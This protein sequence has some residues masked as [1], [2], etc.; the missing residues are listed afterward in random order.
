MFSQT[1][2]VN[3]SN[4]F[5]QQLAADEMALMKYS[6][7]LKS[8]MTEQEAFDATM[9]NASVAAQQYAQTMYITGESVTEFTTKQKMAEIASMSQNKSFANVR[10]IIN[11]YNGGL[12]QLGVT[13]Q[14]FT[15]SVSQGNSVLGN[16]IASVGVGNATMRGYIGSLIA[17]KAATIGLKVATIALNAVIGLGIGLLIS[18]VTSALSAG[19][20]KLKDAFKSTEERI[21]DLNEKLKESAS[22]IKT[23]SDSFR[24]LKANS[25]SIFPRFVE[26]AKGVD[27]FGHN[28][29]LTDEEYKEFLELNNKIAEM[30]PELNM[31]MDSNG[32]AMLSLS[33]SADTLTDSL[34]ALVEAERQAANAEI[35]KKMP[36]TLESISE[37]EKE[38]DKEIKKINE[39]KE[40]WTDTYNDI[41]NRTLDTSVGRYSTIDAGGAAAMKQ[42]EKAAALGMHGNVVYDNQQTTNNGYVF[43]IQWDYE[44]VNM[45]DVKKLY[46]AKIE[47]ESKLINNYEN[48]IAAKWKEINPIIS[49]WL[50]TDFLYNDLNDQ[51]QEIANVMV[52][53]L[54]FSEL[55]LTTQEDVQNYVTNNIVRPLFLASDDVKD[56]FAEI[57]DLQS[58]LKN[59][60]ITTEEF[61]S[62]VQNAFSNLLGSMDSTAVENFKNAFVSGFNQA[63]I[64]GSNFDDVLK[65]LIDTWGNVNSIPKASATFEDLMLS[66][67][68]KTKIDD[69][70]SSVEELQDALTK[71]NNGELEPKDLV[72]LFEKFPELAKNSDNLSEAIK[73]QI[74][75]LTGYEATLYQNGEAIDMSTGIMKVFGEA[76][77]SIESDEAKAALEAFM[78]EV[79]KLGEVVGNTEFTIDIEAEISGMESLWAAMKES[80]SSTGL[81]TESI[82][83]LKARYQDLE[84]Y[85]AARLFEKTANGIHLNTKALRELESEYEK[86]TKTDIDDALDSLIEQYNDLTEQINNASDTTSTAELYAKRNDILDQINDTAELASMYDGLTSAFKRW[87]QAQSIGEEGDMYDSLAGGLEHIKELYDEGLIGTN[88]FRAAVQL[89][90]NEDLSTANID[91]L[92]SA[93][94]NGYGIMTRYFQDSSDG[95]INFLRDVESLNSEWAHMNE[96]GSWEI[97]FGVGSDQ[98][99]A[100][101]LGINVES[102][103]AIMRKLSDY[104][105]DINLD[106]IFSQLDNLQSRAEQANQALI[107]IGATDITFN[108]GTDDIDYLNEQIEQSKTLLNSLYNDDGELNVK[109]SEDDVE[110]AIAVIE[111]LIYR[112]QSLDDAAILKVDTSTADSDVSNIILKLQEFK[113]SYNNLEV[114]TAIGAD[115]TEAQTAC[116]GLLTEISGMDAEILATLGIDTTS[117]ETLNSTINAVTPEVMVKAGLDASL[118]EG[119]QASEH[120]AEG[121]VIWDNNVDKVT[122]WINQ[123]HTASGVIDWRNNTRNVKTYFTATGTVNWTNSSRAQGTAYSSGNWGTKDSGIALGG[124]IGQELVVRNG[125][126]FTIGED[127]AEFFAYKKNDIIFNAEQTRQILANGKITNGKKRGVTYATGTA[128]SSGSG[129][130]T[131][132][133]TVIT[134]PTRG[135]SSDGSDSSS[136]SSSTKE[137]E[138]EVI[139]WIEVAIDR[140]ERAINRLKTTAESTYKSLKTKLGATADEITKVNNELNL[141]SKA[142]DRYIQQAN[143]VGLSSDLAAKVQD[144][145]IDISEY[146]KDTAALIKDYQ[147]WYEKALD[148]SDAIQQLHEN[149]ASLYEDNFDNI[150]T[151]F[152]NQLSLLEHLTNT[153]ESGIDML[154]ARGY[155][156]STKYYSALSDVEKQN[157]SVLNQELANLERA[158]SEAMNSGE[159]EEY[160]EAWYSMQTEINGV[161]EAIADS[162]VQMAEYAKTMR[163]IEWSYFDY[164]QDRISQLTQEADFLIDLMSNSDLYDDRGQFNDTG[165]ATMGLHAQNYNTYM[166]QADQ[167]AQEILEL[168]RQIA[169][170][171]YNT[172]LIERREEL[173]GLQQDSILAAEDE[174]QAIVDM[175]RDGIEIELEALNELIDAYTDALDSA[176]DLYDYQKKVKD[177]TSEISSLQ[178]QLAAYEN[179]MSE[180]TRA[181][182]QKLKVELENAQEDLQETEYEKYISD[183]KV[184]L[185]ELYLEY[186][187]ILNQR[188]DN[189]EALIRNMIDVVNEKTDSINQTLIE[190]ADSVGYT[191]TDNMQR[192]WDGSTGAL[193]GTISKYGDKFTEQ[194]TA[195]Q[196]VL[197]SIQANTAAMIAE[198][199]TIA[200]ST[201]D[202]TSSTTT[203][204]KNV[205]TPVSTPT[206]PT[207]APTPTKIISVGGKINA[208][209]APIYDYAGDNTGEHQYFSKD[210]IYTVLKEQ[211]GYLQVRWHKL[212]SG[213]TGWFKKSDVKAYKAGGLVD[214]TGL[215]K[216]DG[217]PGK[218]ELMLNAEDTANFLEL[219]DTLRAMSTQSLTMDSQYGFRNISAFNNLTD[220]S[221]KLSEVKAPIGNAGT[222]FGD[223]D[224]TIPIERVQDYND[225]VTQLQHDKKFEDMIVSMTIGRIAGKSSL[226]KYKYQW[227]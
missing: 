105:F 100:D 141:Q 42:I 22:A 39:R 153:Y 171:P 82:K 21:A 138:P 168:D 57:T 16:Y 76:F 14:Q 60:E 62:K 215:A 85:D 69:Y 32:N 152:D 208:G 174:K 2:T 4:T 73:K 38:Y 146:D 202:N 137:D 172:D 177:Q 34:N 161:K 132:G 95:C 227:K 44:S 110:N 61:T 163:E 17:T 135:G 166:A 182:V 124:E 205:K 133:G 123:S 191:M 52:S 65:G 126:F 47:E 40:E 185:D 81:T 99:V 20:E 194:F 155:L 8:G 158:F 175:V 226:A 92:I 68:F 119:Y 102:V 107:E 217:T 183:Q 59:G 88:E 169:D 203:P 160:S 193:D 142:Y 51:M 1:T 80:V 184:L 197:S 156:E 151:D 50:Q 64:S 87:E 94:E 198:S 143:S 223:I 224:I 12:S 5:T 104:G 114:K 10:S 187:E 75:E 53:G 55:G 86:Q 89:M 221:D 219:R 145:T 206:Q 192:I 74:E 56:V 116:S 190:T 54:N 43:S 118:I 113:S 207:P 150:Q 157:V 103:Q 26:L 77:D 195:I 125:K 96:D 201:A 199:D 204:D 209:G 218:P 139:D 97:N 93:Y 147:E 129:R 216:V 121:T 134:T 188:L 140:I 31:G 78:N 108:F 212:N 196:S 9:R 186:E 24:E 27:A 83:K 162:N 79:L 30:F 173:L 136:G 70:I 112:K 128:F 63:G 25:D 11:T 214:Y 58:Q 41:L 3:F 90:S 23:V 181:T 165:T 213:I 189:V 72:E 225:F 106:S 127:G 91:E 15:Q 120:N 130:I 167:Y 35:A 211:N 149:L 154:E 144:G 111:R 148:C 122:S 6:L 33:Y 210:P 178:K 67:S 37:I 170:D 46:D 179:D 222:S 117:I 220:I 180:E 7:A 109:Y 71:L 164:T 45:D 66:E 159:I 115:T 28:V 48:M 13:Q 29:S 176:K 131:G 200:K 84:N 101:A 98:E 36:E 49:S 19:W 18:F